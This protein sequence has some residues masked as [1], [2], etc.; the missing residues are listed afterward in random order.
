MRFL[1]NSPEY[2]T[3]N[4]YKWT[5]IAQTL[6]ETL[7][8]QTNLRLAKHCRERFFN[9]LKPNLR[10]GDWT[11]EEDIQLL[12]YFLVFH[13]KW[14]QIN[15]KLSGRNDNIVKNR[16]YKLMKE[17]KLM[18]KSRKKFNDENIA[19][20]IRR[21]EGSLQGKQHEIFTLNKGNMD[22]NEEKMQKKIHYEKNELFNKFETNSKANPENLDIFG[23]KTGNDGYINQNINKINEQCNATHISNNIWNQN[24]NNFYF[25]N[26][27]NINQNIT[28]GNIINNG[29]N[30]NGNNING[31][32][33][34]EN[35]INEHLNE[36]IQN[37][38]LF[39]Q[40]QNNFLQNNSHN[41][42][43]FFFNNV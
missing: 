32:I 14:S 10:K 5:K 29:N 27:N 36:N 26:Q 25:L 38:H 12:K 34:N 33:M 30:I 13:Q 28:N 35:I 2:G 3:N 23:L 1:M 19:E 24:S 43:I 4:K 21:L 8:K 20:L 42:L 41:V 31:N 6:N 16:F 39:P 15:A 17:N 18:S 37:Y 9:H 40:N 11:V 7:K 22:E